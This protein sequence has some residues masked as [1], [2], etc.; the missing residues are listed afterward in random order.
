[1]DST[2]IERTVLSPP[3]LARRWGVSVDKILAL[4][5]RGQ[6]PGAFNSALEIGPG[7]RPRW[8]IPFTTV[9]EFENKRAA[10][11]QGRE[12]ANA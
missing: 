1:M 12:T 3:G 2:T 10:G 9:E 6:L 4:I 7:K 8:K 5:A 11:R